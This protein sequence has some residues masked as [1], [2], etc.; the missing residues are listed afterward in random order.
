VRDHPG[1][2]APPPLI[3]ILAIGAGWLIGQAVPLPLPG[4]ALWPGI[5][6]AG[7]GVTLALW[8]E[9]CFKAIGTNAMPWKPTTAIAQA[10]PYRFTRNPMYLGLLAAQAGT[11]LVLREGWVVLLVVAT[12]AVLH[13][14][15]VLR[16]E[17]YLSAKFGAEY[18]A[19]RTRTRRWI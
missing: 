15:V 10:G 2:I 4:W 6:L 12:F 17:R 14:G 18:D 19:Y 3:A 9:R 11:G 1:V 8:A 7:A 16:E 13:A 5:V